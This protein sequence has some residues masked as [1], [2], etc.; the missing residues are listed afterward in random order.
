[1]M[2]K[3][4]ISDLE[5]ISGVKA[6]TIRTWEKRYG[7]PCAKRTGNN[8]RYYLQ[9]DLEWLMDASLLLKHGHKISHVVQLSADEINAL[10]L[11]VSA[12]GSPMVEGGE[13]CMKSMLLMDAQL[14]DEA[15]EESVRELGFS[16]TIMHHI[17]PFLQRLGVIWMTGS[18]SPLQQKFVAGLIKRKLFAAIDSVSKPTEG[19]TFLLYLPEKES[20][21]LFLLYLYYEILSRGF[22]V[23]NLGRSVHLDDIERIKPLVRPHFVLTII[24]EGQFEKSTR[25]YVEQ[26]AN[27]FP[28]STILLNGLQLMQHKVTS[29]RNY[30]VFATLVDVVRFLD[31]LQQSTFNQM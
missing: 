9:E 4:T 15:F 7:M 30:V 6:H 1:M 29:E 17:V 24:N 12:A 2:S 22:K 18:I 25:E 28:S 21:E 27:V 23:I 16:E 19:P 14:F 20:H 3:Y 31:K 8:T 5:L 11:T 10:K 26:L 13:F